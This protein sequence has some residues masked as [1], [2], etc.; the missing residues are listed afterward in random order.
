MKSFV[1]GFA[2]LLLGAT[3]SK[4]VELTEILRIYTS[5]KQITPPR[6]SVPGHLS[7][8]CTLPAHLG[9]ILE[10]DRDA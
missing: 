2:I 10:D 6:Y 8:L 5:W 3:S 1:L 4:T 9:E 7:R